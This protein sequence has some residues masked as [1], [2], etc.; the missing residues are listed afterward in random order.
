VQAAENK[1]FTANS[2]PTPLQVIWYFHI[3]P[4]I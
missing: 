2:G 3:K 4:S 1:I